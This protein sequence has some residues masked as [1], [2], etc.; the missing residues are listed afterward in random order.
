MEEITSALF[1]RFQKRQV[2]VQELLKLAQQLPSS[3]YETLIEEMLL[4]R[5]P[6]SEAEQ[7]KQAKEDR[8]LHHLILSLAIVLI[9]VLLC[10]LLLLK[11]S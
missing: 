11:F 7:K 4:S 1:R 5:R 6:D 3:E 9:A 10:G 2:T 8:A